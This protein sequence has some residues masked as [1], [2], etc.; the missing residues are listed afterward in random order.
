[1]ESENNRFGNGSKSISLC[2]SSGE[3]LQLVGIEAF[4]AAH[5]WVLM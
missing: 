1:M 2:G 3:L 5:V 4:F